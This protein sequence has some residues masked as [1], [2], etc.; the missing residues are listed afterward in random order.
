MT[1][2]YG[3][4]HMLNI[5]KLMAAVSVILV[6]QFYNPLPG[7]A[8]TLKERAET[9]NSRAKEH[10]GKGEFIKALESFENAYNLHPDPRYLCNMGRTRAKLAEIAPDLARK[11]ELLVKAKANV[12][13]CLG[14]IHK[15]QTLE[16][17]RRDLLFK[18]NQRLRQKVLDA[19]E[20]LQQQ[21]REAAIAKPAPKPAPEPAPK[22]VAGKLDL[23]PVPPAASVETP[24][25]KKWWLWTIV[26]VVVAGGVTAAAVVATRVDE[27]VPSGPMV[28]Y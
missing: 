1:E 16:P 12:E 3:M 9:D 20:R 22:P 8:E 19:L 10:Y 18:K 27:T 4:T 2:D 26:G 6:W 7:Q 25:Y 5:K 14:K 13:V 21:E 23:A 15:D 28:D 17:A 24:L 11:K